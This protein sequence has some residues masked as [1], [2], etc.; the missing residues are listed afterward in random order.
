M[1]RF[2]TGRNL[3]DVPNER[4]SHDA[5]TPR[6]GGIAV[7]L[8]A[9]A[10]VLLTNPEGG[11]TLLIF[12]TLMGVVGLGDD[13][14]GGLHFGLK[15]ALQTVLAAAM[16]LF[17]PPP[18]LDTPLGPVLAVVGV[19][20][21]VA[22][23]NAFNF[24]DGI[25]GLVG[26][27]ALVS[28]LFLAPLVGGGLALFPALGA[29]VAGFLIWNVNPASIFLGDAGSYFLGF[30]L[31]ASSLY[32]PLQSGLW[33]PLACILVFTPLLFDTGYTL[34]RRLWAGK[35]VFSAHREHIYQRITPSP[36]LHRRTSNIYYGVSVLSGLSALLVAAG[37][38]VGVA[39]LAL[40]LCWCAALFALPRLIGG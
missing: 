13:L 19:L 4:S 25:D 11:V 20:W 28:L 24:M 16:V 35:N 38:P 29:A 33:T 1:V 40:A 17:S 36:T 15:A 27:M 10:G 31:A 14:W 22:L 34:A 7:I 39:G 12:A 26:G 3:V 9:W 21:V 2:A 30:F 6:L 32:A 37:W 18:L 23:T 8:G 5:P